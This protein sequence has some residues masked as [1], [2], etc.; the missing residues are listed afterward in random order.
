[1]L[2]TP[3]AQFHIGF[4]NLRWFITNYLDIKSRPFYSASK[5]NVNLE[6][7][8]LEPITPLEFL[9]KIDDS[10]HSTNT[11]YV[12]F[13][14]QR[15]YYAN[16]HGLVKQANQIACKTCDES[17]ID[18]LKEYINKKNNE[19]LIVERRKYFSFG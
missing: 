4:I 16:V 11:P 1:M 8:L 19:A 15:L 7:P 3:Q 17:F 18:L 5:F 12:S 13:N 14:Q 9:D 6:I 10:N 2:Q